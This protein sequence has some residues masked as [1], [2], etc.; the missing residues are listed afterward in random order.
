MDTPP[1]LEAPFEDETVMERIVGL[2][3]MFPEKLRG[4]V[5]TTARNT[6]SLIKQAYSTTRTV[7]WF[8]CSTAA[9]L[10][11]PLSLEVERY[12]YEE[13]LKDQEKNIIFGGDASRNI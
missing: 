10:V 6:T 13:R 4:I 3:E 9:I 11:L 1:P 8:V 5:G 12:Q 7:A 2:T